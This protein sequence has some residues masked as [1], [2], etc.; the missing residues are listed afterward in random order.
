MK[1]NKL[2]LRNSTADF[3]I[4]T[5]QAGKNTIEVCAE[6]EMAWL[7]SSQSNYAQLKEAVR[8]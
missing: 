3:L 4:H 1:E 2:Q 6:G 7:D 5:T 8:A